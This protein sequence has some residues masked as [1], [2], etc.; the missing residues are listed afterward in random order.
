MKKQIEDILK[1]LRES[2]NYVSAEAI[3]SFEVDSLNSHARVRIIGYDDMYAFEHVPN[4]TSKINTKFAE[5]EKRISDL[6]V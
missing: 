3:I 2:C 5:C 4:G 1:E 6:F